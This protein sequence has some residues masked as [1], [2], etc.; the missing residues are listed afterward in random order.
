MLTGDCSVPLQ[1]VETSAHCSGPGEGKPQIVTFFL[2]F[3]LFLAFSRRAIGQLCVVM[4]TLAGVI[5][6]DLGLEAPF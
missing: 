1:C 4:N 5:A 6:T 3:F 2:T